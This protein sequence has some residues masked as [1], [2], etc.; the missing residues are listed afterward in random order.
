[1][2]AKKQPLKAKLKSWQLI[3]AVASSVSLI[4]AGVGVFAYQSYTQA[5]E[6][7]AASA[8][9]TIELGEKRFEELSD[10]IDDLE[11]AIRN[12]EETVVNT[13]GQTL[14]EQERDDLVA[15]IEASKKVW[16]EQKTKLLDLEAA[17]KSLKSQLASD[18][19]SREALVLLSEKIFE[20]ANSDWSP[21]TSQIVALAERIGSVETAQGQ[22]KNEQDRIAAEQAAAAAAA[23]AAADN[24]ARQSTEPT[25]II[26]T[27]PTPD[28]TP[29]TITPLESSPSKQ[30][31]ENIV[32]GLAANTKTTWVCGVCAPGTICGR[33]LLPRLDRI[34]PGFVGPPQSDAD[35]LVVVV[36]DE[37]HIDRYLSDVGLSI[38][39]HEAAHARQHLKYGTLLLSS[40]AGYRGL[41]DGYTD[42]EA[43]AAVEYM[44][45]CATIYRYGK[46][47]G[48][49]TDICSPEELA[50]AATIW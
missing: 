15:E 46:S 19:P 35:A 30:R 2:P 17:V 18:S 50:A 31:V 38:L 7:A 22:W 25:G 3:V 41:P 32:L 45:D 27:D 24:L 8:E 34:Y 33:A 13:D 23:K 6:S 21:L 26:I 16:V 20:I 36:L 49:Y 48:A 42:E 12:S 4:A 1:L 14:E 40:N 39:V 9:S 47:T 28:S 10:L 44:A 37:N 11:L 43:T 5:Q 29:C